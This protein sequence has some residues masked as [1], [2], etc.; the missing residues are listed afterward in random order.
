[1]KRRLPVWF[2]QDIPGQPVKELL[3]LCSEAGVHTVCVEAACPNLSACFKRKELTFMILGG[4]CS[5]SCSFCAVKKSGGAKIGTDKNEPGRVADL[6]KK[7]G[8]D[9]VVITC[10]C[11]D[12]LPDAGAQLFARTIKAIKEAKRNVKVEILIPDFRG[13]TRNLKCALDAQPDVLAHNLETVPRLYSALRP[14]ADYR[15]SLQV[16][17]DAKK[18]KLEIPTK[19]S[20]MLGLGEK[21]E[22]L[23]SAMRDLRQAGCDLLT[24]GQYL[25]PSPRHYPVKRFVEPQE[26]REYSA[27]GLKMG[28][29]SVLAGPKVR[30]SYQAQEAYRC[31]N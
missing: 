3:H 26:F 16:L 27:I 30:S 14:Q 5:R 19:S 11:R 21:K 7:L 6:V 24:L 18:I 28:F 12:D 23:I 8:L 13:E 10:V 17:R 15:R 1:M 25:A 29:K 4:I 20:I 9:Y 2:K 31:M 22:E